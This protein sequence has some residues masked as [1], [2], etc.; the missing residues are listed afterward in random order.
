MLYENKDYSENTIEYLK[1]D[2]ATVPSITSL[3]NN[4]STIIGLQRLIVDGVFSKGGQGYYTN[5]NHLIYFN[6]RR[7]VVWI[8][9]KGFIHMVLTENRYGD[10]YRIHKAKNT[11]DYVAD[12]YYD[13]K[14]LISS[15]I[16]VINRENIYK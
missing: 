6:G 1:I 7:F 9:T 11:L 10:H 12:G 16:N 2:G 8:N 3:N 15:C 4:P 13:S 14:K 5:E